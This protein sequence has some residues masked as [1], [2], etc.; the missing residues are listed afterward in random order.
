MALEWKSITPDFSGANT[1]MANATKSISQAGTVFEKMREGILAEEQRAIENQRAQDTLNET[2]RAHQANEAHNAAVLAE[3]IRSAE[4]QEQYRQNQLGLQL[5]EEQ[6]ML[7]NQKA[8]DAA[9]DDLA[10]L[11]TY[12]GQRG[13]LTDAIGTATTELDT[14]TKLGQNRY[15]ASKPA[16]AK[17][18]KSYDDAL[19]AARQKKLDAESALATFDKEKK[20]P[21]QLAPGWSKLV[22][23]EAG[24]Q[25]LL[26]EFYRKRNGSGYMQFSPNEVLRATQEY[27]SLAEQQSKDLEMQRAN[28]INEQNFGKA[29]HL[30]DHYTKMGFADHEARNL[31]KLTL[32]TQKALKKEGAKLSNI[33][34]ADYILSIAKKDAPATSWAGSLS[35]SIFGGPELEL[36]DKG[37]D[38]Y[39]Q[40]ILNDLRIKPASSNGSGA[41]NDKAQTTPTKLP[42]NNAS[43]GRI[44]SAVLKFE[45]QT[46]KEATPEDI[47]A[48]EAGLAKEDYEMDLKYVEANYDVPTILKNLTS[49]QKRNLG[50]HGKT[51]LSQKDLKAIEKLGQSGSRAIFEGM[52]AKKLSGG[53]DYGAATSY[54]WHQLTK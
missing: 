53:P 30:Q 50:L 29:A 7:A 46:G 49:A 6:R 12:S 42:D 25:E 22:T 9:R 38:S 17:E 5:R 1:A 21:F 41:N 52:H 51:R 13:A 14:L 19:T 43:K 33:D 36:T 34:V 54:W 3:Q 20:A 26:Q 44:E 40:D 24:R 45:R 10:T 8:A 39:V 18:W 16:D 23:S 11:L 4:A 31:T 47:A 32:A 35:E 15:D 27:K 37:V 48:I 28:T 2:I